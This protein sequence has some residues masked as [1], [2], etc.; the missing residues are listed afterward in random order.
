[1]FFCLQISQKNGVITSG[2]IH[3]TW[4]LY[5]I[6]AIPDII[7][8]I[9]NGFNINLTCKWAEI[10]WIVLII[11]QTI[12]F[13]FADVRHLEDQVKLEASPEDSVSF[14]NQQFYWWLNLLLKI[15]S[16]KDLEM[17]DLYELNYD[18]KAEILVPLWE[19]YWNPTIKSA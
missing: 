19:Y 15:G 13:S 9:F 11:A 2:I 7:D 3:I 6:C 4:I 17:D 16:K 1:M 8:F 18:F 14:I 12:L 5:T 10:I